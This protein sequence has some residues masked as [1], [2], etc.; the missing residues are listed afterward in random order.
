MSL[1]F[2]WMNMDGEIPDDLFISCIRS[3]DIDIVKFAG[4]FNGKRIE[5]GLRK[6]EWEVW[7]RVW[8][9]ADNEL[10]ILEDDF[11]LS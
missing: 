6:Y 11:G 3:S 10:K 9:L 4:E 7:L 5:I 2:R 1:V 8:R